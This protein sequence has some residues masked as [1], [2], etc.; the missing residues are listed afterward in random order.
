MNFGV[1]FHNVVVQ[2]LSRVQL[3]DLMDCRMPGFPVLHHLPQSAQTH[4][5]RLSD[6]IQPSPPVIPFSYL[7]SVPES[8]S[9][10]MNQHFESG[11]QSIGT[12]ASVLPMNIQGLISFRIFWLDLLAG[13]ETFKSLLYR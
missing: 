6:T 4:V 8:G 11:G 2:L 1:K 5:H 9:F 10:P 12:S 3:C 7:Q 13:Q